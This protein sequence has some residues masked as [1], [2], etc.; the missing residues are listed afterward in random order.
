MAAAFDKPFPVQGTY[1]VID[2]GPSPFFPPV[3]LREHWDRG[4]MVRHIIPSEQAAL[5]VA[6]RPYVRVCKSYR[7]SAVAVAA[8]AP[9]SD[10]VY[11][12]GGE[13]YPP[14]RYIAAIDDE[15]RLRRLDRP[16]RKYCDTNEYVPGANSTMYST[17]SMTPSRTG[18]MSAMVSEMAMPR[19]CLK[20]GEYACRLAA[21]KENWAKSPRLFN[22]PTKQDRYPS[23]K[24]T[25]SYKSG[26]VAIQR[27]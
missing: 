7:T 17:A 1:P 24:A 20:A 21:D 14:T 10:L 2:Q 6:F 16:L 12:P 23:Q 26:A 27:P 8:P 9:P 15:S 22:N 5:P 11:P 19:V 13:V 25:Q 18:P 4:A 3:C